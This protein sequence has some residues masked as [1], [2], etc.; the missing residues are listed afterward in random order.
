MENYLLYAVLCSLTKQVFPRFPRCDATF[1]EYIPS[2]DDWVK[3]TNFYTLL[4]VCD[5][6]TRIVSE[7]ELWVS[8]LQFIFFKDENGKSS[9]R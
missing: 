1:N 6:A 5:D 3:V 2:E 8:Y 9:V 4:K 7:S